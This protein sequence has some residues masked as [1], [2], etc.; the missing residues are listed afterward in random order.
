MPFGGVIF[1]NRNSGIFKRIVKPYF[2]LVTIIL[3]VAF[4][5]E[6]GRAHV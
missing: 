1:L 5:F 6:I 4:F 3:S 2:I